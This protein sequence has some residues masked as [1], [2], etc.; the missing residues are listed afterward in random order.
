MYR[1]LGLSRTVADDN[2]VQAEVMRKAVI[3][4]AAGV[5]GDPDAAVALCDGKA[6][7]GCGQRDVELSVY[8]DGGGAKG[9]KIGVDL[10]DES[11]LV[12]GGCYVD[13][14]RKQRAAVIAVD[15][16]QRSGAASCCSGKVG[17]IGARTAERAEL[18][19]GDAIVLCGV[20]SE[21]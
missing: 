20:Q 3:A 8:A 13:L 12:R 11:G 10:V 7:I 9:A 2:V 15:H 18:R 19:P 5:I 21:A 1:N 17:K 14:E 16:R 4:L 6:L